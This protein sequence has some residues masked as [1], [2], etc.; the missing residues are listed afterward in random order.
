[1]TGILDDN[2]QWIGGDNTDFVHTGDVVDSPD[3]IA[4]FQLTGRLYN[5][6]LTA[7]H[8]VYPLL[9][10]HEIMN[11]SGD[12]RYVTAEDFKS[13]GG[14]KQ[15]TEA[16]SQ[17]G[18]IGQL[19]MNTLSNVTLDLDG[20]VFVHGGITAE[21]A[22][23][24]VD[25]MNKV[26]KSAMRNRD[27]RNPV[28]GGEGPFWYRGYAQ[29]SERS[30]CK[31]LRKAL[32]H[33]KAKRM[34]IGHTPQLETGQILSR[35]DGQVF[36]I[37]VGISTVYGANCAALEIVGDKITALYCVKGKPDQAR[38]VDLTPKKKW[39]DDAEL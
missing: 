38:R 24:G 39:K 36:V 37:D 11:L 30:V 3:T 6:S 27:W 18:W 12:L 22:R 5:E 17:N 23:M 25:G 8:G 20:N 10:N 32:K 16:W 1:M 26:V 34:I 2:L 9:G 29:D 31:E 7:P 14:Q 35:C 33:M 4:L 13:F 15:R 21:W 19:L 28:F